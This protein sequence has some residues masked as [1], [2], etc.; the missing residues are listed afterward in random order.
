VEQGAVGHTFWIEGAGG[1]PILENRA[2]FKFKTQF[3]S[4]WHTWCCHGGAVNDVDVK[5]GVFGMIQRSLGCVTTLA[6]VAVLV[7][8]WLVTKPLLLLAIHW[9]ER[10]RQ[11]MTE[12]FSQGTDEGSHL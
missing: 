1:K 7:V 3:L 4:F 11:R 6:V 5:L 2:A 10:Y 9:G 8:V 12:F